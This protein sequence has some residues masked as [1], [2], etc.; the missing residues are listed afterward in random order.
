[1]ALQSWGDI[2]FESNDAEM[3]DVRLDNEEGAP[4]RWLAAFDARE[5]AEAWAD[6]KTVVEVRIVE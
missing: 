4:D 1:M 3:L 6:G 5:K 2:E